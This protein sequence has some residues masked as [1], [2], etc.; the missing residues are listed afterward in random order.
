MGDLT[1]TVA[2]KA[3]TPA[4]LAGNR[5]LLQRKCAC[6]NHTVGGGA[7]AEC[8]QGGKMLQRKLVSVTVP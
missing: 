4:P 7:C 8:S 6:G 5:G 2:A 1:A 3:V